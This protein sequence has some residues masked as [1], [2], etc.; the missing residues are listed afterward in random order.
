VQRDKRFA[1]SV[2]LP[3]VPRPR[4][5]VYILGD[6][7]HCDAAQKNNSLPFKSVDDLNKLNRT[8]SW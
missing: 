5:I 4:M 1:A 7:V 6:A 2:K 3:H 8:R